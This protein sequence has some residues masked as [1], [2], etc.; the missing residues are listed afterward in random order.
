MAI[1]NN[2]LI[3]KKPDVSAISNPAERLTY[4]IR[5]QDP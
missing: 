5:I 1:D 4:L 3:S 2:S